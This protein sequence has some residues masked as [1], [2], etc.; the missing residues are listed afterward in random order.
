MTT[1]AYE[2][3]AE[4]QMT[5]QHLVE[6][7]SLP[8]RGRDKTDGSEDFAAR[9]RNGSHRGSVRRGGHLGRGTEDRG[10]WSSRVSRGIR[11]SR[12][13]W[14]ND[15]NQR[16]IY[17]HRYWFELG[18]NCRSCCQIY[19]TATADHPATR[20]VQSIGIGKRATARTMSG[21]GVC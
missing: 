1:S 6:L 15:C 4:H 2:S 11:C 14:G 3:L 20:E 5:D 10:V 16:L 18:R 21:K 19:E 7:I 17:G 13:R 8:R 9:H 12:V